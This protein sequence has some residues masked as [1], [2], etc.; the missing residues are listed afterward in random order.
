MTNMVTMQHFDTT[1]TMHLNH[2]LK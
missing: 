1:N 2:L